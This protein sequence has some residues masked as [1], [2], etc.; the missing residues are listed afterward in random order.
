MLWGTANLFSHPIYANGAASNPDAHVFAVA[1]AQVK[2]AMEVTKELGGENYVFWGGREGYFSLLNTD[3]K[4]ELDHMAAF[5]KMAVAWKN[6]IGFKGQ[7]LIE[8][9]PREPT[10]HQYDYDAQTV[11]GFLK[12]YSLDHDFKLNIEPNHTTL[13]GHDYEHDVEIASRYGFLGSIDSNTGDTLLG[14]DTDQFPM[15]VKKATMAMLVVIRQGGLAPGGLNFDCKVRRE[16]TDVEDM[17]IGHIGAMDTFA[18]ALRNAAKV[19]E[20]NVLP[21]MV[22]ER[23]SSYNSGIGKK[24]EDGTAT[25]EELEQWVLQNGDPKL[26]SGKQ[27]KYELLFNQYT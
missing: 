11:I 22:S 17:F 23:Y 15:D 14:W 19:I 24:I 7:L 9:K 3:T 26:I 25:F 6:N 2:K 5:F 27:E 20:D 1:A 13:A 16:S 8:P 4:R 18:R 12:H 21:K 10:K